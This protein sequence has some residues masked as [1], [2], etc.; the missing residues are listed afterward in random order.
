[1]LVVAGAII[2]PKPRANADEETL[3]KSTSGALW[4]EFSKAPYTNPNIPNVAFA[5]YQ[6]SEKP[7]PSP[8]VVSNVKTE[9][10]KG[11]GKTDDTAAFKSAIQKAGAAG[12]GAVLIP[13]GNYVISDVL[14]I[15]RPGVVLQGEGQ[16]KT[17]LEFQKPVA[18]CLPFMSGGTV[19]SWYGGVIWIE[20][21]G[22]IAYANPTAPKD[23]VDIVKPAKL[24]DF[25]VE[26]A[27]DAVA[28]LTPFVG[29]MVQVSWSGDKS[30][31]MNIAGHSSME[32][33]LDAPWSSFKGGVLNFYWANQIESIQGNRVTFKKPLRLD[34][35]PQWKV[36]IG[37]D[38]GYLT[39]VGVEEL[40]IQFP[41]TV[42][43]PHLRDPGYNGVMFRRT[44]NCWVKNV[45]VVN[46]DNGMLFG[47][48][49]INCT[50]D[51][52]TLKGRPN[53]HGTMTRGMSHDNLVE[54][55]RIESQPN[56]GINTESSSGNVWRNGTMLFGTFDSH[57]DFSFDSV[58]TNITV[59]NTGNPGGAADAGPFVGRR[60]VSWNIRVTN[61]KGE[62]IAEPAIFP[63]GAI[64]GIQGAPLELKETG[65]WHMPD[66]LDKGCVI[67]DIGS[68]PNPPD[69]FEAQLKLR[70]VSPSGGLAALTPDQ[71]AVSPA[72]P[73]Q[74]P[75]DAPDADTGL[76]NPAKLRPEGLATFDKA[77]REHISS[78]IATG[79]APVFHFA[80]MGCDLT[81]TSISGEKL[82]LSAAGISLGIEFSM[83]TATER[84][85]LAANTMRAGD[86]DDA[87]LAAFYSIL[88]GDKTSAAKLLGLAGASGIH[89]RAAFSE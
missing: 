62:W 2:I 57:C 38:R 21:D 53:H 65:L 6:F 48:E 12:G 17:I 32:K 73:G 63:S 33:A 60:M 40:T 52:F 68:V 34:I 67:A 28:K 29:R 74:R 36:T 10:A 24:G 26:V 37:V 46:A 23:S 69:L 86:G 82:T 44:A 18:K 55:F 4:A 80:R 84:A 19:S 77:L 49:A 14:V 15:S 88:A 3:K 83:L 70:G 47:G 78:A 76:P 31:F 81:I 71:L 89:V 72:T 54:N 45:T 16:E 43:A 8:E 87:A 5:G 64:V 41:M 75:M 56:H 22:P 30:L 66:G 11:D 42:K 27:P 85:Q 7:L 1:M 35:Q 20:P 51:G 59:N 79:R 25:S 50:L 13:A 58:R 39:E 9:G 61:G